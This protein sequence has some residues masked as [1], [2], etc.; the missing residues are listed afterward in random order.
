MYENFS[1]ADYKAQFVDEPQAHFLLDVRTV[2][3][4]E[5]ARIAGAVNIPLDDLEDRMDEIEEAAGDNP[6]VLVC[7]SGVRSVMGAQKLFYAGMDEQRLINLD[8]GVMGWAKQG[9]PLEQG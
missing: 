3:E 8:S 6:I 4:F 9:L 5:Q 2:E 7:R 1:I